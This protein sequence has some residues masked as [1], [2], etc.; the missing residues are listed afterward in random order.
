MKAPFPWFGGKRR[1]ANLVWQ[2]FG[3]VENYVEPFAGSLAVLLERPHWPF[4]A[5]R[6]ETVN[7]LDCYIVNFWRALQ[8]DPAAVCN[9]ADNP[10]N[11][12]DLHA[13]HAWLHRQAARIEQ[14]KTDP[15]FF[16]ARVA[17]YWAWGLSSWIGD[18]FCRPQPQ[19]SMPHLGDPGKGVNRK[20]P[21]LGNPGKGVNRQLPH[22][23][24]P[25]QGVNRK[26]PH[27]GNPGQGVN[28][29]LPHLRNPGQGVN[30][31][32]PHL[33]DP[34]KG[35][36]RQLPHLGDPGKGDPVP[37]GCA[38]R[39]ARLLAY[40]EALADRLRGVRVC[41]GD[42]SRVLG[43]SPTH[44]MGLTGVF[45][46]PPYDVDGTDYGARAVGLST[47]VRE[48]AVAAGAHPLMRIALCGYVDEQHGA[49]LPGWTCVAWHAA[50]GYNNLGDGANRDR[51]R[52]WFSPACIT[53]QPELFTTTPEP[54]T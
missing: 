23:R 8:R 26:L 28:R 2:Y 48:W 20:L 11:E 54:T 39:H 51:E 35:V 4:T 5:T 47:A 3:D 52:I 31:Q 38:D 36:N 42:W 33:G 1:C 10:V 16:D 12:A 53:S 30:R 49:S 6:V 46:D 44:R 29:K 37:G 9:A 43:P 40:F 27:L 21:H 19:D 41:C 13:R 17:G 50:G 18:N 7:D 34:G 14:H 25:G 32:L 24:N 22:L 45:L 15:D